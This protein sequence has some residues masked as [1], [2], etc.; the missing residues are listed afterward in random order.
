MIARW[1]GCVSL[2]CCLAVGA[3][4]QTLQDVT[5]A[6]QSGQADAQY[7]LGLRYFQGDEVSEDYA[8][9][10]QWFA[11]ASTQ[12]HAAAQNHLGRYYFAGLGVEKD[13]ALG[14]QLLESAA[15]SGVPD[16]LFDLAKALGTDDATLPRAAVIFEQAAAAGHVE[17][18]VSLGVLYQDGRGVAQDYARALALYDAPA[19]AGHPRAMNNLG[20]M[21]VRGTGVAQDYERAAAYFSAAIDGG[22]RTAMTNLGVLYENGFGV[23]FDE[24]RANELY[25]LGGGG[26][27]EAA[28]PDAATASVIY[29]GRLQAV[30]TSAEGLAAIRTLAQAGD[31]VARFQLG[32]ALMQTLDAS[33]TEYKQSAAMFQAGAQIGHGPSMANLGVMYFRGQ[34]L[35][36]DYVLGQMWLLKARAAGVTEAAAFSEALSGTMTPTQINESQ[37][38][39]NSRFAA[40]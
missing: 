35:P 27:G 38:R 19:K 36:Q 18:A 17:A 10:A 24:A 7:A 9:S 33:F 26:G 29:D 25:R 12:G 6:A 32:W 15:Q 23:P 16:H 39:A 30:D 4:A 37:K 20:L 1:L 31:P 28:T 8:Q 13:S 34:G 21:Y 11:R 22:L 3:Q 14:L 2:V 40:D 5:E